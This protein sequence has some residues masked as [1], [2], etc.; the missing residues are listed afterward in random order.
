MR[1][2]RCCVLHERATVVA[3]LRAWLEQHRCIS[4][5]AALWILALSSCGTPAQAQLGTVISLYSD[6]RLRGYS[7][8]AGRPVAVVDVSY[9]DDG[10]AYAA[11]SASAAMAHAQPQP[12]S[13][14]FNLG[15]AKRL[16][17]G[18]VVDGGLVQAFYSTHA[19]TEGT[20]SFTQVYVG[21]TRKSLSSRI[22]FSP[23]DIERGA[24]TLYVETSAKLSP[25]GQLHFG[26]KIGLLVLLEERGSESG[27]PRWDWRLS[28]AKDAGPVTVHAILTGGSQDPDSPGQRQHSGTKLVL[29]LSLPL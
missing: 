19:S 16:T 10:G 27:K 22:A 3:R 8:S 20:R 18:T 14:Q 28:A 7:L 1:A 25:S 26:A 5:I 23:H 6:A 17:S 15:Y 13:A 9:D 4:R 11:L 12:L 29:G 21:V 2:V 24:R